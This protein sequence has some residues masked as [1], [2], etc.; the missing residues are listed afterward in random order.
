MSASIAHKR[1]GLVIEIVSEQDTEGFGSRAPT[2]L[3]FLATVTPEA[4]YRVRWMIEEAH[5]LLSEVV[6]RT[7]CRSR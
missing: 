6:P 7:K 3:A 5:N 2:T 4:P 1:N